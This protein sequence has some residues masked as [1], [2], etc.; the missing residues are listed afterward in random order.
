MDTPSQPLDPTGEK[1]L[2]LFWYLGLAFWGLFAA[3]VIAQS[4]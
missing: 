4:L 3:L 2:R 1:W